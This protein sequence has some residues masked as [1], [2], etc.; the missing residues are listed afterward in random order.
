MMP[1]FAITAQQRRQVS[2]ERS[3]LQSLLGLRLLGHLSGHFPR[4]SADW[5]AMVPQK[6]MGVEVG[7]RE[8]LGV[9]AEH[10]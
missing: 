9:R 7:R 4:N 8:P 10:L 1:D 2:P 5:D 6:G 3:L